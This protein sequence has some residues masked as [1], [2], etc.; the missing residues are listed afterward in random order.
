[1][2]ISI[3]CPII[4]LKSLFNHLSNKHT[5]A[6]IEERVHPEHTKFADE[7]SITR[8]NDLIKPKIKMPKDNA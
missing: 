1:M 6:R 7:T 5:F 3:V 2:A 4:F 8:I